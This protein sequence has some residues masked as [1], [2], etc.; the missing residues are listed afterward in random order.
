MAP[1][2]TFSICQN[3]K[4]VDSNASEGIDFTVT[5]RANRQRELAGDAAQIKGESSY[6][7]RS[8]LKVNLST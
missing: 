2:P 6:L 1:S 7:K 5:A 4:E 8:E 3:L